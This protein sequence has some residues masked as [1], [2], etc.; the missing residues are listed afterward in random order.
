M[1]VYV[2]KR[3]NSC[4]E[5]QFCDTDNGLCEMLGQ[6]F[7][8][9]YDYTDCPLQSLADY[10]KQVRKEVLEQVYKVFTTEDVWSELKS[11]W[12]QSGTC[13]ELKNCLDA[14]VEETSVE[15]IVKKFG[16][17]KYFYQMLDQI[18]GETEW[19]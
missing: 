11:W 2:S 16:H 19:K 6:Y 7:R 17:H 10:T 9:G 8:D 15:N 14:M 12:L 4:K 5:C 13:E 3:P 18:Q 1:K